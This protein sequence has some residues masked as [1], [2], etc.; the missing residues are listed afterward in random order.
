VVDAGC[1]HIALVAPT[2]ADARDIMVLGE[3]GILNICPPGNKPEPLLS[4]RLLVWPNG[5][6]AMLYSADEPERL[7]GHQHDAAWCDEV[8]C[9]A[10]C[11]RRLRYASA[12]AAARRKPASGYHNHSQTHR[13]RYRNRRKRQN[14]WI[15]E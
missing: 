2:A 5:A 14:A 12:W 10:I 6:V 8:V 1:R 15:T 7:R 11:Q 13:Y 3:S 4:R 9:L